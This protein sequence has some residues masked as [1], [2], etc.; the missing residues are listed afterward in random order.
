MAKKNR[1]A[2]AITPEK[3][4]EVAEL[5]FNTGCIVKYTSRQFEQRVS[6]RALIPDMD[7]FKELLHDCFMDLGIKNADVVLVLPTVSMGLSSYMASQ[8]NLLIAQS[9][10]EDLSDKEIIFRDNEPLVALTSLGMST[11]T[12][13]V[14]YTASIYP[15]VQEAAQIISQLGHKIEAIDTSFAATFR[16]LI[17]TGRAQVREGATWLMLLVDGAA[18]RLM[19]LN[20]EE[21]T[22]YCEEQLMFDYTDTIGNCDMV[23]SAMQSSIDRIPANYLYV[24]SRTDNVSAEILAQKI[25]FKQDII[26]LEANGSRKEAFIDAPSFPDDVTLEI[27]P[28]VIGG[29]LYDERMLHFNLFTEELGDVY[30]NQ[31]PLVFMGIT[32]TPK[33]VAV[34][35]LILLMPILGGIY[36]Y[37][38]YLDQGCNELKE[39][40]KIVNDDI[41]TIEDKIKKYEGLVS[42]EKFNEKDEI[43][44]G[45]VKNTALYNYLDLIG[46][47]TPQK[48]WLTEFQVGPHIDIE[49]QSDSIDNIY[50]FYRNIKETTGSAEAKLQKL[51]LANST[52]RNNL[53][54]D[55]LPENG[56]NSLSSFN[57]NSNDI[58]LSSNAD[59]YEF[60][61]SDKSLEE[62]QKYKNPD[63]DNGKKKTNNRRRR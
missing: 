49:G 31:Q 15:I 26:F 45:L 43:N 52:K 8:S 46:R 61:I 38:Y 13:T 37:K 16:T 27:S 55:E 50:T 2:V 29:C 42:T 59:F 7:M 19:A 17:Q 6:I 63:A 44:L 48:L 18:A 41:K 10:A 20:G 24:V 39:Q 23:V 60:V 1:V 3:G 30:I 40:T 36:G 9:I 62:L 12:K 5:N 32:I 51:S 34:A 54:F 11:Q 21:I 58:I 33:S 25:G 47:D 22:E 56:L 35:T 53:G 57:E 4:I 28:D 14:A